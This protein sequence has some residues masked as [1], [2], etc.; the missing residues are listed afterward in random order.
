MGY[1]VRDENT[2]FPTRAKV[3]EI[4]KYV[5]RGVPPNNY[6]TRNAF[7]AE[8]CGTLTQEGEGCGIDNPQAWPGCN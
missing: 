3:V 7:C 5:Q 6:E 2:I 4:L 8:S 1:L